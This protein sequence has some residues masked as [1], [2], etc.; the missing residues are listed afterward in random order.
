MMMET[1]QRNQMKKSSSKKP[2]KQSSSKQTKKTI[3]FDFEDTFFK[4]YGAKTVVIVTLEASF[5][6]CS[7]QVQAFRLQNSSHGLLL[8]V[9][10]S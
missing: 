10:V 7:E 1:M 2:V 4:S 9:L 3:S 6:F 8:V 5:S